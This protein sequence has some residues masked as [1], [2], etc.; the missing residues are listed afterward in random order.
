MAVSESPSGARAQTR[1]HEFFEEK[2]ASA[3]ITGWDLDAESIRGPCD[4]PVI[5]KLE[6]FRCELRLETGASSGK[7]G[8]LAEL[9]PS[10]GKKFRGFTIG[11]AESRAT[12]GGS[13][14]A[15]MDGGSVSSALTRGIERFPRSDL[16]SPDHIPSLR[17]S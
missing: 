12:G 2:Q 1:G 13:R 8:W 7:R 11:H 10:S 5:R 9:V 17:K 16:R 3:R 4:R 15:S 14:A 6:L